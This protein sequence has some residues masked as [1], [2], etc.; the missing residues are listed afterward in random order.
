M[1][2]NM[3]VMMK[4]EIDK[5]TCVSCIGSLGMTTTTVV[6]GGDGGAIRDRKIQRGRVHICASPY[7]INTYVGVLHYINDVQYHRNTY[8]TYPQ[9]RRCGAA[10]VVSRHQRHRLDRLSVVFLFIFK[11]NHGRWRM[12]LH[13]QGTE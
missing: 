10:S 12:V 9:Y 4:K 11:N 8:C 6:T 5:K 2:V 7:C 13:P 1:Y 3:E